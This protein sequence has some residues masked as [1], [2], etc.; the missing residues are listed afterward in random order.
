M[1]KKSAGFG[2]DPERSTHY[3]VVSI[4]EGSSSE[5]PVRIIERYEWKGEIPSSDDVGLE[6]RDLKA[7][8]SRS[9]FKEIADEVKAEFNRRLTAHGLASGKWL[10]KGDIPLDRSFGKELALLFWA[11]ED[12][13]QSLIPNAVRNW[14]GLSPEERWWLYTMTNAATGQAISGRNKGW[15]K[16][17]RFALTENPI[18]DAVIRRR[19]RGEELTLFSDLE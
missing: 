7:I 17:V 1:R 2:F 19:P 15:R 6:H 8:I 9:R 5:A 12:A 11:I 13:E 3:F 16:A 4:P 10:A 14:V 18:S